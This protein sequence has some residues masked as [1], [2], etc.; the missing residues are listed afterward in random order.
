MVR[1]SFI[2]FNL[3]SDDSSYAIYSVKRENPAPCGR[4]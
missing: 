1:S 2:F 3:D 4:G